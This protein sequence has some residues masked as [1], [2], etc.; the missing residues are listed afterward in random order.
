MKLPFGPRTST[1]MKA[2]ALAVVLMIPPGCLGLRE[3]E[4]APADAGTGQSC[5]PCTV[6]PVADGDATCDQSQCLPSSGRLSPEG[7]IGM[8]V[9]GT[10]AFISNEQS[11]RKLDVTTGTS[12]TLL[13]MRTPSLG[14]QL[15]LGDGQLYYLTRTAAGAFGVPARVDVV[16]GVS[17]ILE[18]T[19]TPGVD[20]FDVVGN[21]YVF[22]R[23]HQLWT[24][25]V[26]Q[27]PAIPVS[28][29]ALAGDE[30]VSSLKVTP[31]HVWWV[32]TRGLKR[33]ARTPNAAVES[34]LD[35]AFVRLAVGGS[36][37]W[38]SGSLHGVHGIYKLGATPGT[39]STVFVGP[40]LGITAA[41]GTLFYVTQSSTDGARSQVVDAA[42]TVVFEAPFGFFNALDVS[43]DR[44][45]LGGD[46]VWYQSNVTPVAACGCAPPTPVLPPA[47]T[48]AC[49]L[50]LCPPVSLPGLM[51]AG[52]IDGD[53]LF[54]VYRD[55]TAENNTVKRVD[56]AT[57]AATP[58]AVTGA[59]P[60]V[61]ADATALYF[62]DANN[63]RSISR[64]T[65]TTD[66]LLADVHLSYSGSFV[67]N[68]G[69]Q[70]LVHDATHLYFFDGSDGSLCRVLK[71][72]GPREVLAGP[73]VVDD[74]SAKLILDDTHVYFAF[75]GRLSR[76]S[77]TGGLLEVLAVGV[78]A[79]AGFALNETHAYFLTARGVER[80]RK[81]GGFKTLV[82][83]HAAHGLTMRSLSDL[84]LIGRHLIGTM[85]LPLG[86]PGGPR[87]VRIDLGTSVEQTLIQLTDYAQPSIVTPTGFVFSDAT[88]AAYR[89]A[90]CS[91]P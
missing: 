24:L 87:L 20:A 65:H 69:N 52:A 9:S 70:L 41:R 64:A 48:P 21:T 3:T 74:D 78:E 77:K 88:G 50:N 42:G 37:V 13:H 76:V 25:D 40:H 7:A 29:A 10:D 73:G 84:H 39:S 85:P 83:S 54:A 57:G 22:A 27:L 60:F 16:T 89:R 6:N 68:Y 66:L 45:L 86:A 18:A 49:S 67:G 15:G 4:L 44:I 32:G 31:T 79:H 26:A 12:T 33:R 19:P 72:G 8:V 75:D 17:T 53:T 2:I 28:L 80:V 1:G 5:D 90:G 62:A 36:D 23:D 56:L 35:G 46:G 43:A 14:W 59:L 82:L 34:M 61:A 63:L 81:G 71:S 58:Y 47:P 38:V 91:C 55:N 30:T 11:L 51:R